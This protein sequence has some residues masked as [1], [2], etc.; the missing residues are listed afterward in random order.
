MEIAKSLK[1]EKA[2]GDASKFTSVG[3]LGIGGMGDCID[4]NNLFGV[5][6]AS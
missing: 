4:G 2:S 3:T 1:N 6:G 5:V